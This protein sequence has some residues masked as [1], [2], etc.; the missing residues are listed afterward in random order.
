MV[1]VTANKS[2]VFVSRIPGFRLAL[3][4]NYWQGTIGI[5]GNIFDQQDQEACGGWYIQIRLRWVTAELFGA[6][7]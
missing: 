1:K 7:S 4:R 6:Q 5:S 3:T 2:G